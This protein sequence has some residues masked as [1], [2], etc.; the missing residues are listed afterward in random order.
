MK[1][2][3]ATVSSTQ[4]YRPEI[5]TWLWLKSQLW[6]RWLALCRWRLVTQLGLVS[7][8]LRLDLK[9]QMWDLSQSTWV[10]TLELFWQTWDLTWTSLDYWRL[11]TC[12]HKLKTDFSPV[13]W[14]LIWTR[15]QELE[16]W[17][18]TCSSR[19][20]TWLQICSGRLDA[21]LGLVCNDLTLDL[22]L[23]NVRLDLD[24]P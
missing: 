4:N 11:E 7:N 24:L 2:G 19:L 13:V 6:G 3:R 14:D 23:T 5:W 12:S 10:L 8:Y 15:P 18:E 21:W 16:M 1:G 20:Q 22:K 9:R 17:L